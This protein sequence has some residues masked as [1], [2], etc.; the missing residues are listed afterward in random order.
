MRWAQGTR[1]L[2]QCL[3]KASLNGLGLGLKR[4][5]LSR[6]GL[7]LIAQKCLIEAFGLPQ[8]GFHTPSGPVR[9]GR[10]VQ[11]GNRNA[12]RMYS[13]RVPMSRVRGAGRRTLHRQTVDGFRI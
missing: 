3:R 9:L 7:H 13:A 2:L 6:P 12:Q 10:R 8:Y 5:G 11:I 4:S 1:H